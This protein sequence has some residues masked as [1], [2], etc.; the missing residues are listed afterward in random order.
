[1]KKSE[2][3]KIILTEVKKQD[4]FNHLDSAINSLN[5]FAQELK[6]I[7]NEQRAKDKNN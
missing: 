4:I 5:R 3:K 1:M 2:V 6:K 7:S